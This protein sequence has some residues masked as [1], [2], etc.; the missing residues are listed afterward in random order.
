MEF[1]DRL[2][3]NGLVFLSCRSELRSLN[4]SKLTWILWILAECLFHSCLRK[5]HTCRIK[6]RGGT[7]Y[8]PPSKGRDTVTSRRVTCLIVPACRGMY[9]LVIPYNSRSGS[10]GEGDNNNVNVGA[11][12]VVIPSNNSGPNKMPPSKV[13]GFC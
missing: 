3:F 5:Y 2:T 6:V 7:C 10:I 11:A 13:S 8:P 1:G 9:E 12:A 4:L